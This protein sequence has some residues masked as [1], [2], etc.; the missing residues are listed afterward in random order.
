MNSRPGRIE[1]RIQKTRVD[2][3]DDQILHLP[4]RRQIQRLLQRRVREIRPV[5]HERQQRQLP[6]LQ[7]LGFRQRRQVRRLAVRG[8]GA[9]GEDLEED[10]VAGKVGGGGEGLDGGGLEQLGEEVCVWGRGGAGDEVGGSAGGGG[11]L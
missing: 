8:A 11:C 7:H 5:P 1:R 6:E 3:R 4:R 9:V 2:G 10:E